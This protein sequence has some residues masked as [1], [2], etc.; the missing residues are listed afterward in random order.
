MYIRGKGSIKD[1]DKV[2]KALICFSMS[3]IAKCEINMMLLFV[4][5]LCIILV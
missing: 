5:D 4:V 1:P 2:M 3:Y